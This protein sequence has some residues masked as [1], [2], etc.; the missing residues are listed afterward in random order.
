MVKINR[1]SPDKTEYLQMLPSIDASIKSMYVIGKLPE[2]RRP[3]VAI[4]GSRKFT[5]YGKEVAYKIAYDLAK[6]GIVIVSG[7]ALGIDGV[8]HRA[9]LDAGGTTIAVLGNGLDRIYPSTHHNLGKEIIEKGGAIISEYPEGTDGYKEHFIARNR[10]VSAMSDA[11]IV[12]EAAT[13]SGTLH[14]AGFALQQGKLVCAVPGN[15]TSP[16]SAGCNNLI[17]QGA[18]LVTSAED[19]LNELGLN[20]G[21][22]QVKLIFGDTPQ[23]ESILA[24]MRAGERDGA[25]LQQNSGLSAAEFS[26]TL[27]MLEIK[28]NVRAVGGNRWSL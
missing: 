14:T 4:V 20:S 7:L 22:A 3:T 26:Q 15:V 21:P 2:E 6:R 27:T 18:A 16:T 24:L 1:V 13:K 8:A 19:V 28:G 12:V 17:K 25:V 11:L 9:A 23:E 5:S 10:I